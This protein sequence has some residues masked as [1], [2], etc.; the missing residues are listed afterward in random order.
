MDRQRPYPETSRP[1]TR[2]A[3]ATSPQALERIVASLELAQP[4]A[5]DTRVL[6]IDGRSGAG[7]STLAAL[8]AR[9]LTAPVV[10]LEDLYGGWD[11]LSDGVALLRSAVL[12]PLAQRRRAS[13]PRYDWRAQQWREPRVIEPPTLLIVEGV[14]AGAGELAPYTSLLVW[15]EDEA[16]DRRERTDARDGE[17]YGALNWQRWARQE[18]AYLASERPRER[19][20]LVLGPG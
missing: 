12:E 11:G 15:L 9:R 20:D 14:G 2:A 8:A 17:L 10:S 18:E 6:A 3:A 19:A 7:K 4:R 13:V 5:G 1:S 16:Q